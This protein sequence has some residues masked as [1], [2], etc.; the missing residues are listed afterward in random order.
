MSNFHCIS[1]ITA[2]LQTAIKQHRP[3]QLL[4][5]TVTALDLAKDEQGG[6]RRR[7]GERGTLSSLRQKQQWEFVT[8][9]N[10]PQSLTP[11]AFHTKSFPCRLTHAPSCTL[12]P[13]LDNKKDQTPQ[14]KKN[15]EVWHNFKIKEWGLKNRFCNPFLATCLIWTASGSF[16]NNCHIYVFSV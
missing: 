10:S 7:E 6:E 9:Q 2:S 8:L 1:I 4:P 12:Q 15:P 5:L 13:V 11:A 3:L 16:W 14:T